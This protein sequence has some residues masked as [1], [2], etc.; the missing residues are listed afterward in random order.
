MKIPRAKAPKLASQNPPG[1]VTV[2]LAYPPP[3]ST[4]TG[5]VAEAQPQAPP[6]TSTVSRTQRLDADA[7]HAHRSLVEVA[8]QLRLDELLAE[9]RVA[10]AGGV[11]A[12]RWP[13]P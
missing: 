11:G 7:G 2:V 6:A 13:L 8:D 12:R 5:L 3:R 10:R 4:A 1:M 9:G